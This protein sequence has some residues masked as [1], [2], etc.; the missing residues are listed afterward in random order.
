MP[1]QK[2]RLYDFLS[3]AIAAA[4][5]G[6]PLYGAELRFTEFEYTDESDYG[7][8]LGNVVSDPRPGIGGV[9]DESDARL[10]VTTY[11]RLTGLERDERAPAY[12]QSKAIAL[13]VAELM[14]NDNG[15]NNRTCNSWPGK[16]IDDYDQLSANH[17][18]AVNNLYVVLNRSGK[19]LPEPW[20]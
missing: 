5:V 14:F 10:I 20:S 12:E 17:T 2:K 16:L 7:I 15:L 3:E 6:T 4:G 13:K 18:H 8:A 9:M 11:T 1:S 19:S